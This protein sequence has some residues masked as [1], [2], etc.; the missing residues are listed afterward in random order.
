MYLQITFCLEWA[1]WFSSSKAVT[2][3]RKWLHVKNVSKRISR[4][5]FFNHR[6][7][8]GIPNE[9]SQAWLGELVTV[10]EFVQRCVLTFYWLGSYLVSLSLFVVSFITVN[11]LEITYTDMQRFLC[12]TFFID[13]CFRYKTILLMS[14]SCNRLALTSRT[15]CVLIKKRKFDIGIILVYVDG[16]SLNKKEDS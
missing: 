2:C 6:R 5:N 10:F 14:L 1:R 3:L 8:T 16:C 15:L 7:K 9:E 11:W 12:Q 13:V 4:L